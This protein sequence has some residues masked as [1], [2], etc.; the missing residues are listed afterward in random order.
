[1]ADESSND[2]SNRQHPLRRRVERIRPFRAGRPRFCVEMLDAAL[3][4]SDYSHR[5]VAGSLGNDGAPEE[6]IELQVPTELYANPTGDHRLAV[7]IRLDDGAI[8]IVATNV[9]L[10][11]SL[12]SPLH[13]C[14][15][16][17]TSRKLLG[18]THPPSGLEVELVV[19]ATGRVE[20]RLRLDNVGPFNRADVPRFVSSFASAIDLVEQT[21]R[22]T[23]LRQK[24]SEM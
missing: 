14:N 1:M 15:S 13:F 22:D 2:A 23:G 6:W 20:A 10:Q 4:D 8:Q 19:D 3:I 7:T 21:I 18:L 9:Y 24:F 5:V 17:H 12:R 11:G 16:T